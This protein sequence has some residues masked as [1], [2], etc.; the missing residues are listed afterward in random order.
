M[1]ANR[2][3]LRLVHARLRS[4]RLAFRALGAA[5]RWPLAPSIAAGI[6]AGRRGARRAVALARGHLLLLVEPELAVVGSERVWGAADGL[7]VFGGTVG[8]RKRR[9]AVALAGMRP[10]RRQAGVVELFAAIVAVRAD[11]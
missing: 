4:A 3:L 6:R 10:R 2:H 8:H 1:A 5:R 11:L 7:A 9:V